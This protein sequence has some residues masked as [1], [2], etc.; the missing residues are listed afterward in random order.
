MQFCSNVPLAADSE[1]LMK[2]GG[3][4]ECKDGL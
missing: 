3:F 2:K 4:Y 1:A